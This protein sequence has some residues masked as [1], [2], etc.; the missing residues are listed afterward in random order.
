MPQGCG[1][2]FGWPSAGT[3][4]VDNDDNR[5]RWKALSVIFGSSES[6]VGDPKVTLTGRLHRCRVRRVDQVFPCG[7][8]APDLLIR[9]G[10]MRWAECEVRLRWMS[11]T[12]TGPVLYDLTLPR[13]GTYR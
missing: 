3:Q 8:R 11:T 2:A 1:V 10:A 9:N 4:L 6:A 12:L 13:S 5:T 7:H